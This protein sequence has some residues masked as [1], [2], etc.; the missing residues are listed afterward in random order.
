M[1]LRK[2][3]KKVLIGAM[4]VYLILGTIQCAYNSHQNPERFE[5]SINQGIMFIWER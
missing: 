3:V 5:R 2:P 4:I 1:K